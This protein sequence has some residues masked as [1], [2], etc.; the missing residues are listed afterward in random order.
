MGNP[1]NMNMGGG[2]SI[3]LYSDHDKW[4]G[5]TINGIKAKVVRNISDLKGTHSSLPLAAGNSDIYLR[6]DKFGNPVQGRL[7]NGR[8]SAIDFDWGH[9]H[10]NNPRKGG[11]GKR[12][13]KGTVHVQEYHFKSDGTVDRVSQNA[14]LMNHY[15]IQKYGP[16][17]KHFSPNV[18]FK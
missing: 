15:E 7:Y 8:L 18:K 10:C 13:S 6:L 1:R 3:H 4:H 9:D 17:L 11:D 5:V 16:I 12:F 14:R 2:F